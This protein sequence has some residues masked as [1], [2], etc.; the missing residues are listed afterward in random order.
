MLVF[1]NIF[2]FGLTWSA[3][4]WL[5]QSGIWPIFIAMGS[6]QVG[7]CLLS[8]PMCKCSMLKLVI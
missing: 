5:I 8:I 6:V 3:Y 7:I 2:S 1:K 4:N